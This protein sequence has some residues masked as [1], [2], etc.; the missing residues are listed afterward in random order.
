MPRRRMK[1][2]QCCHRSSTRRSAPPAARSARRGRCPSGS[3]AAA[4]RTRRRSARSRTRKWAQGD[5]T[6]GAP[7]RW[8][9]LPCLRPYNAQANACATRNPGDIF[10]SLAALAPARQHIFVTWRVHERVF[11]LSMAERMCV[12]EPI[13]HFNRE[14]Y[15]LYAWVV[16]DDHVHSVVRPL[17]EFQLNNIVRG[18]KSY[19]A[20]QLQRQFGRQGAVWQP[21]SWDRIVRDE[22]E[23]LEKCQYVLNNP[24]KRWPGIKDYPACGWD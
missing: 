8:R 2:C 23:L 18:W 20:N 5:F 1:R 4:P 6:V 22:E 14:R 17:A 21:E 15:E 9:R 10:P 19:S 16:M 24:L 11:A 7:D 3:S 12:A 13:R